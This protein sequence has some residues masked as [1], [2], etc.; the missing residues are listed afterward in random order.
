MSVHPR[1][2]CAVAVERARAACIYPDTAV[3]T[4][5]LVCVLGPAVNMLLAGYVCTCGKAHLPVCL[6]SRALLISPQR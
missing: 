5:A 4:F 1:Y 2:L 6:V 3:C